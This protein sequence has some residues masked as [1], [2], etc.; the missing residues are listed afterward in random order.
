[1]DIAEKGRSQSLESVAGRSISKWL[2]SGTNRVGMNSMIMMM[3]DFSCCWQISNSVI[4]QGEAALSMFSLW[5]S[6]MSSSSLRPLPKNSCGRRR[7]HHRHRDHSRLH[8]GRNKKA[9]SRRRRPSCLL[10]PPRPAAA[11]AAAETMI[12]APSFVSSESFYQGE[13]VFYDA[14]GLLMRTRTPVSGKRYLAQYACTMKECDEKTHASTCCCF[15]ICDLRERASSKTTNRSSA[16][17]IENTSTM[18]VKWA[19]A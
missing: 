15:I 9:R 10:V 19:G 12:L 16:C 2:V 4:F 14:M 6:L 18:K 7:H 17:V 3:N 11:A 5:S 13:L 8:H 1:M